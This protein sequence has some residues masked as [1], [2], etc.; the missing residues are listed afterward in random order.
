MRL[1]TGGTLVFALLLALVVHGHASDT[2][3]ARFTRSPADMAS[4]VRPSEAA[5][6]RQLV[7]AP[8][9]IPLRYPPGAAPDTTVE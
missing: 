5:R 8:V 7:V 6:R 2:P 1:L 3:E 9:E 4:F